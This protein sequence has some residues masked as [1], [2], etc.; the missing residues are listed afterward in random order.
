MPA[1]GMIIYVETLHLYIC[2]L[3]LN[4]EKN[5]IYFYFFCR[6]HAPDD[7]R[8]NVEFYIAIPSV[9]CRI[10]HCDTIGTM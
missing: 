10:L 8:Y 5:L 2:T 7:H 9:Q 6:K 1:G 3:H 4:D